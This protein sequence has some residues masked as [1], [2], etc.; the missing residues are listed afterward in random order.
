MKQKYFFRS[1]GFHFFFVAFALSV[2]VLQSRAAPPTPLVTPTPKRES[3]DT[4]SIT[5]IH[6][7]FTVTINVVVDDSTGKPVKNLPINAFR[8]SEN[9]V[10]QQIEFFSKNSSYQIMYVP[11]NQDNQ[12]KERDVKVFVKVEKNS[13]DFS[14]IQ[15]LVR[16]E[17]GEFVEKSTGSIPTFRITITQPIS[18]P[19]NPKSVLKKRLQDALETIDKGNDARAIELLRKLKSEYP[20]EGMVDFLWGEALGNLANSSS[21]S[22]TKEEH[23]EEAETLFASAL[24]HGLPTAFASRAFVRLAVIGAILGDS[25]VAVMKWLDQAIEIGEVEGGAYRKALEIKRGYSKP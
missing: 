22:A 12:L 3:K 24:E 11:S 16:K 15:T 1:Y 4:E 9:N 2:F 25:P 13:E 8:I 10:L 21:D 14:D 20:E 7:V 23:F 19:N 17:S 18:S 5:V 6:T